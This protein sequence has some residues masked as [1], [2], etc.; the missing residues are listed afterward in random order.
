VTDGIVTP[1]AKAGSSTGRPRARAAKVRSTMLSQC[2]ANSPP[3]GFEREVLDRAERR[4]LREGQWANARV[5]LVHIGGLDWTVKDFSPRSWWVRNSI[6][7]FLLA[8]ELRAL[9]R[10]HGLTGV[11][12]DSFRIDDFALAARFL[13]GRSLAQVRP[14]EVTSDYFLQLEALVRSMHATGL[15]HLDIRGPKNLLLMP[16]G[17]PGIIDFQSSLSTRW[18][19]ARLRRVL[20]DGDLSGIYKRWNAWQPDTLDEERRK[21]LYRSNRL[22]RLWPFRG[23]PTFGTKS[24]A[25]G[26]AESNDMHENTMSEAPRGLFHH[27]QLRRLLVKLRVPIGIVALLLLASFANR[28]W[29]LAGFL[30]SMFGELI[31]VWCFASLDKASTLAVRGPYTMVRN[32]MYL[33]RYFIVLGFM[34]LLGNWWVLAGYTILYWLY[35]DARVQREERRLRPIFG[36]SYDRYCATVRRF[37]PGLPATGEAVLY[38]NWKLFRQ[39]HAAA[40][41]VATI[42]AWALITVAVIW[43]LP[44]LR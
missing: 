20:E 4:L 27:V 29:L 30:V 3:A 17:T 41:A 22:R 35:M 18:M 25:K 36:E 34:M 11:T 40:N 24:R 16:D 13:P 5:E 39:N 42:A 15:V 7:R 43:G 10:L 32:P 31:Q 33:G 19:P 37:V 21:T 9:Q 44:Y 14:D 12:A 6:G 38:W 28:D 8:R 26:R 23:Y 2:A 1:Q